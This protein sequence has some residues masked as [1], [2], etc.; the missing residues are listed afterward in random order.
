MAPPKEMRRYTAATQPML[1]ANTKRPW[2]WSSPDSAAAAAVVLLASVVVAAGVVVVGV[3]VFLVA[4][5][6]RAVERENDGVRVGRR[7][8]RG[9]PCARAVRLGLARVPAAPRALPSAAN[10]WEQADANE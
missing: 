5:D 9:L 6:R 2:L 1:T 3:A 7:V 4:E 10:D 8:R